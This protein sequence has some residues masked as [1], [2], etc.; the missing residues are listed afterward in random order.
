MC[1]FQRSGSPDTLALVRMRHGD[2]E[3]LGDVKSFG[4]VAEAGGFITLALGAHR[5]QGAVTPL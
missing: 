4:A 1:F 3:S 2:V 5:V